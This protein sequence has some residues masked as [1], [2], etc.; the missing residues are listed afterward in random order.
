M[1]T[2]RERAQ[3]GSA[4]AE[5]DS[6]GALA[7][8]R[9]LDGI[10]DGPSCIDVFG[11]SYLDDLESI[12]RE[13]WGFDA[14]AQRFPDPALDRAWSAVRRATGVDSLAGLGSLA[15]AD[16]ALWPAH[17]GPR[18]TFRIIDDYRTT[19]LD[20]EAPG[21]LS[22]ASDE[23][24]ELQRRITREA[25]QGT[26]IEDE[27]EFE[28]FFG[29]DRPNPWPRLLRDA[30]RH[31]LL[32]ADEPC[33]TIGPRWP[34]E[35][36]WF[37]ERVGLRGMIGLDLVSVDPALVR[38]G[39]MHAMPF[40]TGSLGL[41]FSRATIDKSRDPRLMASEIRR[42]LRPGGLVAIE[43]LGPYVDGVNP[44]ARTDVKS[45]VGLIR[46]FAPFVRQVLHAADDPVRAQGHFARHHIRAMI[47]LAEAPQ[48]SIPPAQ[49]EQWSDP[50][51]DRWRHFETR[52][53]F[54][55]RRRLGRKRT[56]SQGS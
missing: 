16:P 28:L 26:P 4:V 18:S 51:R 33:V 39:D 23:S 5:D 19:G 12:A 43:T 22:G 38:E 7:V 30:V 35:V 31:G 24:L 34:A 3:L 2:A 21:M 36:R 47:Q 44:L 1:N 42:V 41:V 48:A 56:R 15:A 55:L 13:C 27:L 50:W 8:R 17:R 9:L 37:R 14:A 45:S 10:I 25:L 40:E 32:R 6:A 46:L 53:R 29:S 11:R 52:A 20:P 54:W 49:A